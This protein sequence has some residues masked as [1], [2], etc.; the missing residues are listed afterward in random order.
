MLR[1]LSVVYNKRLLLGYVSE[2][3]KDLNKK[4]NITSLPFIQGYTFN[5]QED[6]YD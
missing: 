4:Y 3:Q 5:H 6:K 2:E 1:L